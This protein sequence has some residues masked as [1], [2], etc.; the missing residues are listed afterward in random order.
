M[1]N[2]ERGGPIK[3]GLAFDYVDPGSYLASRLLDRWLAAAERAIIVEWSGLELRV[4]PAP[5]IDPLQPEWA[6]LTEGVRVEAMEEGL[7]LSPH[8]PIPWT[9]KAHELALHAREKGCFDEIRRALFEAHFSGRRDIGR[10]DVLVEIGAEHG[11]EAAETRTVLGIDR[12]RPAVESIRE[13]LLS[14]GVRG[15]PTVWA[16]GRRLEGFRTS[17]ALDAFLNTME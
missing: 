3:V 10:V 14:Q 17:A 16:G 8:T 6:D 13:R 9:R 1:S 4:P 11:L 2:P 7:E 12:F 5:R 15:V